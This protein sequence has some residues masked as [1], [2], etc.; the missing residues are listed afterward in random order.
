MHAE[1]APRPDLWTC[2]LV[3]ALVAAFHYWQGRDLAGS[4]LMQAF[5]WAFDYD[6][7]RFLG[8]WCTPG[9][10]VA[11]DLGVA[12][13]SRHALTLATR[14]LCLA[15]LPLAGD[16]GRA[17]MLLT[18]L[19]AGVAA[20]L[21]YLV[22]AVHCERRIDRLLLA[23]FFAVSAQPLLLGVMPESFGFALAGIG[24]HFLLLARSQAGAPAGPAARVLSCVINAGVTVTN[25]A[26]NAL[27]SAVLAWRRASL[28]TWL[29]GEVRTWVLAGIVLAL[30]VVPLAALFTPR[31]LANSAHAPKAVWWVININRGEAASLVQ[32]VVTFVLYGMVAPALTIVPLPPPDAHPMLDFRNFSYGLVGAGALALWCATLAGCAWLL[33]RD[34][35]GRR[36]LAIVGLW[37]AAN[38]VLHWYW[39]YRGSVFL[40]GAHTVFALYA[41]VAMGYGRALAGAWR[42]LARV[43]LAGM[44]LLTSANN[45][46]L[47]RSAID[48]LLAQPK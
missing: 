4:V 35:A 24:F 32:V 37:L 44:L 45:L 14:P 39:Q 48:F 21:A 7:S 27:S 34:E 40:Y 23:G 20:A 15:L 3:G 12:D 18:A 1:R 22:A 13:I 26:L 5:N 29:M 10:D 9:A 11:R 47:Y 16:P 2:L 43:A 6:S 42:N 25:A 30:I 46:A 8:G 36:L 33:R 31:V 28:K 19:C 17:L 38:I 41:L